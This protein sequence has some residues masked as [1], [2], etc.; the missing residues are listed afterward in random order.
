MQT[1]I[2]RK[3]YVNVSVNSEGLFKNKN[4]ARRLFRPISIHLCHQKPDTARETVPLNHL[5]FSHYPLK[6]SP[7][8]QY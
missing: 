4:Q 7:D 6:S 2:N 1:R 8:I 5:T 3:K